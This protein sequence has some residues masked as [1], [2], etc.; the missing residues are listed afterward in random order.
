MHKVDRFHCDFCRK[1]MA[2]PYAMAKHEKV[3][4]KNPASHSCGTCKNFSREI[5]A[6]DNG[7]EYTVPVCLVN[8]FDRNPEN[9]RNPYGM[10]SNCELYEGKR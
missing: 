5:Q 1:T 10:K 7:L 9:Q 8:A 6:L 4:P 3:C 2:S